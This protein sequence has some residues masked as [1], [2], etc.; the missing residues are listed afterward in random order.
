MFAV[1]GNIEFDTLTSPE[2][3]S[4]EVPF[5]FAT[6][7]IVE[8]A[9]RLQWIANDL[10]TITL[11][12]QFHV[13]FTNPQT[14]WNNLVTQ[15]QTHNAAAL[16]Y[17]NGIFEGYFVIEK[18][19][20]TFI[21]N[22]DDGSLIAL[23]AQASLREYMPGVDFDP[24]ASPLPDGPPPGIITT[25]SGSS[26]ILGSSAPGTSAA[27]TDSAPS[28]S[29]IPTSPIGTSAIGLAGPSPIS[30]SNPVPTGDV[31]FLKWIGPSSGVTYSSTPF[32]T[33]GVGAVVGPSPIDNPP[34]NPSDVS[35]S[36]IVR[37]PSSP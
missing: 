16:V 11:D 3:L 28:G 5:T 1:Y 25:T 29:S 32:S 9:P 21:A 34:G 14:Q 4:Q 24:A 31:T 26:P 37:A 15:A 18:L 6:H 22:A 27:A 35:P 19:T 2:A 36:T 7:A 13:A 12:M 20:R 10:R 30:A 17:G 8:S 33:P 23:S